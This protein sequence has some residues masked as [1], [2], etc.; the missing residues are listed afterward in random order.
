MQ[1][2]LRTAEQGQGSECDTDKYLVTVSGRGKGVRKRRR[3]K[4]KRRGTKKEIRKQFMFYAF[5][6]PFRE[7]K[8]LVFCVLPGVDMLS[9]AVCHFIKLN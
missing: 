7:P 3:K 2:G 1:S 9:C 8:R 5:G 4:R 6:C